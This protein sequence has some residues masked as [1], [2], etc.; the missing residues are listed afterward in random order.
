MKVKG[1][2]VV[3]LSF[4]LLY[5]PV[6]PISAASAAG[7]MITRGTAEINGVVAP[8]VTSVFIGDRIA[9]QKEAITSLSFAGGDAIV[10]PELTKAGLSQSDGHFVVNLGE[11]TVSVLNK[12]QAPIV[13]ETHGTRIFAASGQPALFDV[14]I[15]GNLLRVVARGG[16]AR[17][18]TPTRTADVPAGNEIDATLAPPNP[19]NPPQPQAAGSSSGGTWI[20][21]GA[22]VIASTALVVGAVALDKVSNCTVSPSS[23]AVSC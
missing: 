17:V 9:T 7:K 18:E 11:G 8:A 23:N 1:T 22:V 12:T 21:V 2:F 13:V 15:S 3:I 5:V 19:A 10:M 20:L 4:L 6:A 14:T 16:V